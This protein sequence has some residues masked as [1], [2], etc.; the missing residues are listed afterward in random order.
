[1][2]GTPNTLACSFAVRPYAR[3]VDGF[4]REYRKAFV[5]RNERE[6]LAG[7]RACLALN[8][9]HRHPA[10]HAEFGPYREYIAVFRDA[11]SGAFVGG[12]NFV[13]YPM[14]EL[15]AVTIQSN[16]VFVAAAERGKGR[17]RSIYAE[18]ARIAWDFAAEHDLAPERA[19]LAFI[20]EQNDP[21]R[22]SLRAYQTDSRAAQLDQFDRLRIWGRLGARILAFN[23]VQPALSDQ[24]E[25]DDTL[26]MRVT[27][28]G[29]NADPPNRL[30]P[31]VF[32]E[33]L[34][35]FFAVSVLKGVPGALT[36]P[37]V[38]D[39]LAS[40]D[41]AIAAGTTIAADDLPAP[42]R[43]E[44]WKRQA[45]LAAADR[46]IPAETRLGDILGER[47]VAAALRRT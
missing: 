12:A 13:C 26:F 16:Y 6:T 5:L 42:E 10:L 11:T 24:Q 32:R 33:H 35:R 45:A 30:D 1:M 41:A 15:G 43:L 37:V 21:F 46:R 22:M 27:F 2:S 36:L 3:L 23:Y 17:L 19:M 8:D 4:F 44:R 28:W 47:S 29:R 25:P 40:L 34:R 7:F 20:G 38:R 14:A 9:R 18:M 39:Q 31:R